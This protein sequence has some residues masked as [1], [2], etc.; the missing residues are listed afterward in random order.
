MMEMNVQLNTLA[1]LHSGIEP[2]VLTDRRP[3]R[4]YS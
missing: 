2:P 3:T 4:I 1:T